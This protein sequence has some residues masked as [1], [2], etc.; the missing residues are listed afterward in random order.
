MPGRRITWFRRRSLWLP[1]LP[2]WILLAALA[3]LCAAL[4]VAVLYP[5]LSSGAPLPRASILV[6][7]GWV[8]DNAVREA[9]RIAEN[10]G[11]E[12]ICAA[13][14]DLTKGS[15]L[16]EYGDFATLTAATLERL[17]TPKDQILAA[18][19]GAGQRHRTY[20]SAAAVRRALEDHGAL[21]GNINVLTVGPHARR[22]ALVY[23]KVF[24]DTP[25]RVGIIQ[26][27]PEDYDPRRWWST[28]NGA[29]SV[30]TEAIAWFHEFTLNGG[31]DKLAQQ[32]LTSPY[33]RP[34]PAP[35][36]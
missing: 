34:Q 17:G 24:R 19:G 31:R 14:V 29:K 11:Y 6:I 27:P 18:P 3:A 2:G 20:F 26:T 35:A 25:C 7:E 4:F 23:Q 12:T 10:E 28:S 36:Q 32:A 5:F 15:L 30:I 1:T 13:G 21:Q 16:A 8:H 33:P 9:Q 22:T